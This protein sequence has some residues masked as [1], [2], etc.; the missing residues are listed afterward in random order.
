MNY[1]ASS[2]NI[3]SKE[4]QYSEAQSQ[5]SAIDPRSLSEDLGDDAMKSASYGIANLKRIMPNVISWTTTG[6]QGQ[7]YDEAS[8]FYSSIIY[9]WSC[10]AITC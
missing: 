5:R 9:Q 2:I 1:T 6:E 8:K 10:I 3:Q 7:T 4:Y